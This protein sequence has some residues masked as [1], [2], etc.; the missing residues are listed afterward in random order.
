MKVAII[1]LPKSGK[2]TVFA[3]VT[4]RAIDPYA[5]PEPHH[6]VVDIP[7]ERIAYLARLVRPKKVTEATMEFVDLPGCALADTK[8]RGTGA[9]R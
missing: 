4:E 2:S 3:V 7:D 8:G 6:A 5:P 1:G 9:Q